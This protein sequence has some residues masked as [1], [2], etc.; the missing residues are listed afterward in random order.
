M[1]TPNTFMSSYLWS[2]S[3]S[4]MLEA[5]APISAKASVK[6]AMKIAAFSTTLRVATRASPFM[7]SLAEKPD[8]MDR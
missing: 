6:P 3:S 7:I 5:A 1:T 8:S 4:P 2:A